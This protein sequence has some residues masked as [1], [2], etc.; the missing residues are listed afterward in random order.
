MA[1]GFTAFI[2]TLVVFVTTAVLPPQQFRESLLSVYDAALLSGGNILHIL[3]GIAAFLAFIT[4]ANAAIMT[5]SRYP[6]GMS[7]DKILPS[8]F[9]KMNKF[10]IPFVAVFFTGSFVIFSILFLPLELLVKVASSILILLYIFANLTV[11]LFRESKISSYQPKFSSP[12][13]PYMQILGI[14]SGFFLLLEMGT[15]IIFLMVVFLFLGF[16]WYRVYAQKRASK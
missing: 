11:I 8:I 13:Y 9:Q 1:L 7:R 2:Y 10:R 15:K 3:I 6:L 16:L 14:L 5:A 4:T 12:F